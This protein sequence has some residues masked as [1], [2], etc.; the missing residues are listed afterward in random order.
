MIDLCPKTLNEPIAY[1]N[2]ISALANV[3]LIDWDVSKS[4]NFSVVIDVTSGVI[5]HLIISD[6]LPISL[7]EKDGNLNT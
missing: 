7:V 5:E 3:S 1:F 4:T 2:Y 6:G